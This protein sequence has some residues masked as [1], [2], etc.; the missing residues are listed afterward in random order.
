MVL[1]MFD[2]PPPHVHVFKSG[3]EVKIAL[4]DD[5]TAP[6]VVENWGLSPKDLLKA[7]RIVADSQALLLEKW[8]QIHA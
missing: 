3:G 8:R 2:H 6:S 7:V 1:R 4:G 5:T